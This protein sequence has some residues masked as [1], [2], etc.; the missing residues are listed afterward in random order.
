MIFAIIGGDE[1]QIYLADRLKN[2]KHTVRMCGFEKHNRHIACVSAG[3]A[4]FGADC[5]ILPI[6][7]SRDGDRVWTPLGNEKILLED[8]RRAADKK[9]L[10]LSA[11]KRVG[12]AREADYSA[13]E[14]FAVYNA[15]LT[16]EGA[17]EIAIR[18]TDTSLW[19]ANCLIVGFGRIGKLLAL[20]LAPFGCKISVTERRPETRAWIEVL[21]FTAVNINRIAEYA[22]D[23]DIIFN[24]V[25]EP[26]IKNDFLEKL[27]K[28]CL[29][30]ELASKPF[31]FEAEAAEKLHLRIL[32]ASGLPGATAPQT[33]ADIIYNTVN[34]ITKEM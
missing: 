15:A 20:K 12:T 21:G 6:P 25:P 8:L 5:V 2:E 32:K 1:R 9:T 31:G 14:D 28:S 27:K 10:F 29:L 26:V 34:R 16:A 17:M 7:T 3:D 33:A 30:M 22:A 4:L 13:C 11:G 24:T 23:Y 18:Q 19:G